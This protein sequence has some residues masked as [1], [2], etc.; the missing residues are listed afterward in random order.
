MTDDLQNTVDFSA[1]DAALGYFYQAR[2]ALLSSLQRLSKDAVFAVYL[3]TLDDVVFDNDGSPL[4][5][6][7]LKHH[8]EHLGNLTNASPDL[9]K[10]L[11]I[12]MAGRANGDIPLDSH[13]YLITTSSVSSGS[14]ASYLMLN[15]RNEAEA[16]KRLQETAATSTNQTNEP[17]YNLFRNLSPKEHAALASSIVIFPN[18]PDI[19][20][21]H[22]SL[23][24]EARHAVRRNHLDSFLSRLEGWW[25]KRVVEQLISPNTSPILSAEIESKIDSL[26]DQFKEDSL[27]VD[28]DILDAEVDAEIYES[29]VFVQQVKLTG[30][31]TKRIF[32]AIRDYYRAFEQRSRWVREDLLLIGELDDYEQLLR[33]EW[34][35]QFD[36]LSDEL[37]EAAAEDAKREAARKIYAWVEDSSFPIRP[38]VQHPSMTRGSFHI[39]ADSLRVGWHPEFMHRL[40]RVLE[41]QG[42]L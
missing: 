21:V 17:A 7:Q 38:Q 36:R 29:A 9:W 25:Y 22:E 42:V 41:P 14:T 28:R 10:S 6:L 30:I 13:L 37:G 1:T 15:E 34:E 24:V 39:L 20:D 2:L 5:L 16:V 23:R 26:R 32:A 19:A 12:W 18:T 35:L 31:G 3:E 4:E 40:Q 27:P 33:E 11:R 8:R